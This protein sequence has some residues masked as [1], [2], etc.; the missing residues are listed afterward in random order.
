MNDSISS[1]GVLYTSYES[2]RNFVN[3]FS[4]QLCEHLNVE[5]SRKGRFCPFSQ[6]PLYDQLARG[7]RNKTL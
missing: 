6:L 1:K 3:I 2:P 7:G 4:E 5:I